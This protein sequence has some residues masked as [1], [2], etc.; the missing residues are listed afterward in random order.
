MSRRSKR[1]PPRPQDR[2]SLGLSRAH[3]STL[4]VWQLP[5][6]D[7]KNEED[8]ISM[9]DAA[10]G[11]P[12]ICLRQSNKSRRRTAGHK[13]SNQKMLVMLRI[14]YGRKREG[15]FR[16]S[17]KSNDRTSAIVVLF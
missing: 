3:R 11:G 8:L 7:S 5:Q 4:N 15:R 2:R 16:V 9:Q 6:N 10:P 14:E 1:A 17:L 12:H 13:Y